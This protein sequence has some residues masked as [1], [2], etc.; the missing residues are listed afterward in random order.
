MALN[1]VVCVDI[2]VTMAL[3]AQH[4]SPIHPTVYAVGV[5]S[6]SPQSTHYSMHLA[7]S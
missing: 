1:N 2:H 7:Y 6:Q 4:N 5:P 3:K